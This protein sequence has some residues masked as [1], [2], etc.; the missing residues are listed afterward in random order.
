MASAW[1]T[2][3]KG[4]TDQAE[5]RH[6]VQQTVGPPFI[7]YLALMVEW[8]GL[9]TEAQILESLVKCKNRSFGSFRRFSP[10][11]DDSICRSS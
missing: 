10:Y 6:I 1:A 7:P 9:D 3:N 8:M 5:I 4:P 11:T 2:I